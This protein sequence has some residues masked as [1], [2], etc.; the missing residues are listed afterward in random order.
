MPR[1]SQGVG[2]VVYCTIVAGGVLHVIIIVVHL[3]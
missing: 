1:Q 2:Q 3:L